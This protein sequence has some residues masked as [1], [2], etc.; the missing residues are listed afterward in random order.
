MPVRVCPLRSIFHYS[1]IVAS[2]TFVDSLGAQRPADPPVRRLT[3][4]DAVFAEPFTY[5]TSARELPDGRVIVSDSRDRVLQV[6][7]LR[8][9]ES[10]P[11]GRSGSGPGEWGLPARLHEMPGDSTL[12]VDYGNGRFFVIL[13]T[14]APGPTFRLD[15]AAVVTAGGLLGVDAQG[16]LV[17]ERERHGADV[18]PMTGGTGIVDLFRYD[19]VRGRSDTIAQLASTRG[20]FSGARTLPGGYVQNYTNRPFAARDLAV[21]A[22]DGRI[23]IVRSAGYHVEWIAMDGRRVVGPGAQAPRIRV[24]NAEKE[25]FVRSQIRPGQI[26]V[27]GGGSGGGSGTGSGAVARRFDGDIS[28]LVT[29]DMAW[30]A[31]KPPFLPNAARVAR[32]GQLWVLRSRAHDDPVPSYDVFNAAGQVVERVLLPP[33]TRLVGFGRGTV[34]LA[35]SDEDDLQYLERY[36]MP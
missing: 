11:V 21:V 18:G 10:R 2:V 34:Y 8:S 23:G 33:G 20:E 31:E 3:S 35:R 25:A 29:P 13:P 32:D 28:A 15:D 1:A 7:D 36:R 16:R 14:G 24:T 5:V 17:F 12:M 26:V 22:P 9:G 19:R 4:P 27:V 6:V 30:P